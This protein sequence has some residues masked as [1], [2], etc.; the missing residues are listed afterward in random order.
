MAAH[1]A[2]RLHQMTRNAAAIIGIELI[3]AAQGCD[4][5]RGLRSSAA[6]EAVRSAVRARI[7]PLGEDRYLHA[8]LEAATELVRERALPRAAGVPLPVLE[9][10]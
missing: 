8:D 7:P 10:V 6:L 3:T 9:P 5:H 1:A 4:F 2:R